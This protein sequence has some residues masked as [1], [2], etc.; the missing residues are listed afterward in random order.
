GEVRGRELD[1]VGRVVAVPTGA[2]QPKASTAGAGPADGDEAVERE[3]ECSPASDDREHGQLGVPANGEHG[4]E[5]EGVEPQPVHQEARQHRQEGQAGDE[6]ACDDEECAGPA[7]A[8]GAA[9]V[10]RR[11]RDFMWVTSAT[12]QML[13]SEEPGSGTPR[14]VSPHD[15][16]ATLRHEESGTATPH[17]ATTADPRGPETYTVA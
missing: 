14:S 4:T 5:S 6:Q 7:H 13:A 9:R 3:H 2:H 8:R 16:G 11:R 17:C 10:T 15:V 12:S 1:H